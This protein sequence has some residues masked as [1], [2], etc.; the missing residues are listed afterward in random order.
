MVV[1]TL[2]TANT[3]L[4]FKT[5]LRCFHCFLQSLRRPLS[6]AVCSLYL[7]LY[8]PALP[9]PGV[10]RAVYLCP[11]GPARSAPLSDFRAA[12]FRLLGSLPPRAVVDPRA[13][14]VFDGVRVVRDAS[15]LLQVRS[16]KHD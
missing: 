10:L 8:I 6:F 1:G 16:D 3:L 9:P 12:L 4:K 14:A 5:R 7:V 11:S 13:V 2:A 15:A